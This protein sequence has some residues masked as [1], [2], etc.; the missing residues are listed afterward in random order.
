MYRLD[1][2]R[3]NQHYQM[4]K[5]L[6]C[7]TKY[8]T[9]SLEAKV[10]YSFLLDRMELSRKNN[11]VNENGNIYLIFSRTE[12]MELMQISD[13]TCTKAFKQL[14]DLELIKEVRQG[15]G[16]PNLIFIGRI[17]EVE[18]L[19]DLAKEELSSSNE[20]QESQQEELA[21]TSKK[22]DGHCSFYDKNS[23]V[24]V[25]TGSEELSPSIATTN[26]E[27]F[28]IEPENINRNFYDS[29]DKNRNYHE[30][31][32]EN[33]P[34]QESEFLR[35]N[36]TYYN[37]DYIYNNHSFTSSKDIAKQMSERET[38]IKYFCRRTEYESYCFEN[39]RLSNQII[40]ILAD[41]Y[42]TKKETI[43]I[44]GEEKPVG[45]VKS[46]ISKIDYEGIFLVMERL[47]VNRQRIFNIT[48]YLQTLLYNA[49]LE[50]ATYSINHTNV[51]LNAS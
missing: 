34:N 2:V 40:D 18:K 48:A 41:M 3:K 21:A 8:R 36:K 49:A 30:L 45:I 1:D 24:I 7:S 25:E 11:W 33:Y 13:K 37:K 27:V 42:T 31:R 15:R 28:E 22:E 50:S 46:V 6:F 29:K 38:V 26:Y 43:R 17:T 4:P 35:P 12:I 51:L 20:I 16:K 14:S 5:E 32:T 9:L 44:N 23:T 19:Q 39:P 47:S 10:L